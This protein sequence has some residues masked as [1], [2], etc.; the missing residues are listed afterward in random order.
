MVNKGHK[1]E[2]ST[3]KSWEKERNKGCK[4]ECTDGKNFTKRVQIEKISPT[5]FCYS[6]FV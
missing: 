4:M 3:F 2:L 5:L 1:L 6:K